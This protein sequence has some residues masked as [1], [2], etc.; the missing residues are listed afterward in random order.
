MN[1]MANEQAASPPKVDAEAFSVFE[2]VKVLSLQEGDIV[3]LRT[4]G[5][6]AGKAL[7]RARASMD[8][9]FPNNKSVLLEKGMD[10]E[11]VRSE[12]GSASSSY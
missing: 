3:V 9:L 5:W 11:I 1:Q 6:L 4:P 7:E 8:A 12:D 10:F 2:A